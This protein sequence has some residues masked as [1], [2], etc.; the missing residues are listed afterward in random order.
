M[1][2]IFAFLSSLPRFDPCLKNQPNNWCTIPKTPVAKIKLEIGNLTQS[3]GHESGARTS[4]CNSWGSKNSS[5]LSSWH[6]GRHIRCNHVTIYWKCIF[7]SEKKCSATRIPGMPPWWLQLAMLPLRQ[8]LHRRTL[9]VTHCFPGYSGVMG[10]VVVQ[11]CNKWIIW[12]SI[13]RP[14]SNNCPTKAFETF[15]ICTYACTNVSQSLFQK[16]VYSNHAMI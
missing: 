1:A 5:S 10:L 4:R 3:D 6:F 11:F 12:K 8:S 13:V 9:A 7:G 15:I 16:I 14:C 2:R